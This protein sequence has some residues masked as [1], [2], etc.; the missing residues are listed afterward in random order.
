ISEG[1][2]DDKPRF[3]RDDK[4]ILFTSDRDGFQCIWAQRIGPDMHPA[5]SPFAVHH[6]HQRRHSL[7]NI[8]TELVQMD[9]GPRMIVFNRAELTG[10][11][12]LLDPARSNSRE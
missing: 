9:V 5:G 8:S 10:E 11:I 3:S 6:S 4:L 1:P 7:G 12:W 2:W